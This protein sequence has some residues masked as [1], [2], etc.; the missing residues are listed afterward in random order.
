MV[1]R[2]GGFLTFEIFKMPKHMAKLSQNYLRGKVGKHY[3]HQ[4]NT[5]TKICTDNHTEN[6]K[7]LIFFFFHDQDC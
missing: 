5:P 2:K 4:Q 6:Q 7:L 3:D 1:E